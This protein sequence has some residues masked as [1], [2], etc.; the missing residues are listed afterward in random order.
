[1]LGGCV[2]SLHRLYTDKDAIF[3][4]KLVGKWAEGNSKDYWEFEEAEPNSYN[5]TVVDDGKEGKFTAHLVKID[6]MMF[7]DLFPEEPELKENDFYKLHLLPVHTFMEIEQIEPVLK[8]NMMDMEEFQKILKKDP[9]IV[10]YEVLE[11]HGDMIILTASTKEL[12]EFMKKYADNKKLF[13]EEAEGLKRIIPIEPN[14]VNSVESNAES[15][16]IKNK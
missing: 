12:Q 9:A 7:L 14:D 16:D 10:K 15:N 2:P 6:N 5:L 13:E 1:M 8:M 4:E 11:D 3:E